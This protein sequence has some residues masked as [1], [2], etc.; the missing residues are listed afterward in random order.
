MVLNF[1]KYKKIPKFSK[2]E[3]FV[4]PEIKEHTNV[5]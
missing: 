1:R 4:V 2:I 3:F 5:P